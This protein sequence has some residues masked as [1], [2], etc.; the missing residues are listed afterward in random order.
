MSVFFKSQKTDFKCWLDTSSIP[1]CLLSFFSFSNHNPDSFSIP[2]G[3][4]ENGSTFSIA[5][6]HLV[7]RSI[8]YSW[9]CWVVPRHLLDTLVVDDHISR[10]LLD[11]YFDTSRYLHLLRFTAGTIYTSCAIHLLFQSISLSILLWFLSQILSSHS[12]NYSS[13]FLQAFSS[14]SSLG[15]LLILSHSCISCFET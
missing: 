7:D 15:K 9:F 6:R 2:G 1:C 11:R 10:H 13:R 12:F 8:F 14:F 5:S 3:S 4:I